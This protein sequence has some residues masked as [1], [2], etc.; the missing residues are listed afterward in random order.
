MKELYIS[1]D[2]E[3][4]MVHVSQA[5]LQ[6]SPEGSLQNMDPNSIID[7]DFDD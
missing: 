3:V 5:L 4:V 7:E 2:T 6:G 1:P